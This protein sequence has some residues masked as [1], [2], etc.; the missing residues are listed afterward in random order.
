MSNS[1]RISR[2]RSTYQQGQSCGRQLSQAIDKDLKQANMKRNAVFYAICF[3]LSSGPV[4]IF[5]QHDLSLYNMQIVPQRIFQNPAFIPEQKFYFGIP[6]LSGVQSAYA[7]PFSYNDVISRDSYDSITFKVENFLGKIS[8][9]DKMRL[10]SNLEIL[11]LGTQISKGR[12]FLGFSVR[13]RLSQHIMIPENLCNL[14]WYGNAAPQ[15]FGQ[16]LNVAPSVNVTAFDEW[17]VSFSGYAMKQKMTWGGR[18]KYLS[19]RINARTTK[20]EFEVYTDT[21]TYNIYMKSDF[22]MRTSGINDIE[23]YLDQRV[24]SLVFPGNNGFGADLGLSYQFDDHF[25]IN[26]SVLDIGFITWKSDNMT[27]ISH[28]PGQEFAFEGLTLKD[29]VEMLADLETFGK[30]MTDSILDLVHFDSVYDMKYTTWLPVRYNLGGSYSINEHHR[31]NLLLNGITWDHHLYP[32][33][34]V[35]YY[36]QLP[37]ILGLMVSYNIFNRQFTNIGAG[38]SINAGP[39]QLY[40]ISDNLPGLLFYYQTNS[41][42]FQFGINISINPKNK[43]LPEEPANI[44]EQENKPADNK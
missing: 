2:L 16:H 44:E 18:L 21:T 12:F 43:P 8:K 42:S 35:S 31:F 38:L 32:A 39:M 30:K 6:V 24:S 4:H 40:V 19:G 17:G 25:S 37:R 9:N 36:Y 5:A 26:A 34:S 41:S 23:H 33:L 28:D 3:L 10:Y 11:S 15:L 7:N 14:L 22:E 13:E 29:F 27:I 20:S 1:G